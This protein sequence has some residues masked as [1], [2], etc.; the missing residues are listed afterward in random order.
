LMRTTL[1]QQLAQ[2]EL[3]KGVAVTGSLDRFEPDSVYVAQDG[4]VVSV[5]A[6]GKVTVNIQAK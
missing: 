3:Y 5:K 2:N 4:L 1:R 6:S